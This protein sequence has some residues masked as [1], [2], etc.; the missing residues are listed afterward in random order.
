MPL[1]LQKF[2][3]LV[4]DDEEDNLHA[5]RFNFK[6]VFQILTA[7]GGEEALGIIRGADVAVIVTDQRMP[8]MSGLELLKA[9]REARPEAVGIILTAF[10][11]VEVLVDSINMGQVYRYI[12][13]PWDGKEVRGI[14]QQAIERHHLIRENRRLEEQLRQY[15][16]YL[17]QEMHGRFEFG[18]IVGEAPVLREVLARVEQVAPTSSTVLLRGET[19]TGK[20]L[21][22]HAIHINSARESGPFVRV[23]CA[24]LAPG[25]LESELFGHEKGAFTGAIARRPGRFELAD[26]GTLFLDEIGDLPMEVQIKLLRALQEREFE[27]V[28]GSETIKVNVRVVSATNR[29]LEALIQEGKFRE[30]LYYRLNVFPVHLPPLRDR[31]GDVPR[32]VEHFVAKFSREAGKRIRGFT[33]EAIAVLQSYSWPGN[34]R[35]LE[36]VVER[37]I[38]ISRGVDVGPCDLDFGRRVAAPPPIVSSPPAAAAAAAAA[39]APPTPAAAFSAAAPNAPATI[40]PSGPN[41][42]L[43]ARLLEEERREIIAAIERSNGTIAGAARALGINRSTLYY[44]LRK[45]GLQHLLP[46]RIGGE[47]PG[48]GT[49]ESLPS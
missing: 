49:E 44:R 13:K 21:V 12:T 15:A 23:N 37:A 9:A 17:S 33:P 29:D 45:H 28:G 2:P 14:L 40:P 11:D 34:V 10:T 38:I 42:P 26:G 3:I 6:R 36:N 16:G 39:F 19:G 20:E 35:E 22:A 47:E 27:R 18:A 25:V 41:R 4:V 1:D 24:A 48:D 31:A 30:D 8:K 7:T 43:S 46:T 32:L 5:F